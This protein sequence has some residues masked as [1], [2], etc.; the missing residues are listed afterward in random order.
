VFIHNGNSMF[1][2]IMWISKCNYLT[3]NCMYIYIM[4]NGLQLHNGELSV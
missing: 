1:S 4:G 3:G 2:Y